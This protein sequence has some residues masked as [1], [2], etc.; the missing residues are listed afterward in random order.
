VEV[1]EEIA[2]LMKQK[3]L[4]LRKQ[5]SDQNVTSLFEK[6]ITTI[7]K[8]ENSIEEIL[9]KFLSKRLLFI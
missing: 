7:H 1:L 5:D 4:K 2:F 3:K 6:K 8:A 9:K